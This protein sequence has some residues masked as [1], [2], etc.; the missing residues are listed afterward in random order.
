M[1]AF[2][3]PQI[4]VVLSGPS[5]IDVHRLEVATWGLIPHWTRNEE[6]ALKLRTMTLN[7]R[8]ET[9]FTLS[10]FRSSAQIQH[11]L[12][13]I[14]GFYE[15]QHL[16]MDGQPDPKG[17]KTKKYLVTLEGKEAFFLG[18]LWS[19]WNHQITFTIV[20]MPACALM[21]EIH[22]TKQRQPIILSYDKAESWLSPRIAQEM[23]TFLE[24]QRELPLIAKVVSNL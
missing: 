11:C 14:N 2:S 23:G 20:T 15:Y 17:K 9:M 19:I 1:D 8:S 18:G 21:S 7:A 12:V 3:F 5:L 4:P 10:S 16:N 13:P 24:D 22:N 6:E